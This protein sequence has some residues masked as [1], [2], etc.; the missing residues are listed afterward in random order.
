[1]PPSRSPRT[2]SPTRQPK[3][4][5]G[6]WKFRLLPPAGLLSWGSKM[7]TYYV[8]EAILMPTDKPFMIIETVQTSDGPRSRI[9]DGRF[10]SFAEAEGKIAEKL[11]KE[12]GL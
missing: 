9:C 7:A 6:S 10:R 3:V 8:C 11:D 4:R 1:M 12:L 2:P 5:C